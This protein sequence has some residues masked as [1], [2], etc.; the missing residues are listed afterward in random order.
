MK[1]YFIYLALLLLTSQLSAQTRYNV[2]F[3]LADD[4][5]YDAM[6]F[7]G[8]FKGLKTPNMDKMASGGAH[9]KNAF[10][11]TALCSPSR[12][13][14]LTG[15]YPHAH[16]VVD[17]QSPVPASLRFFPE[18]LQK[19]GYQTAFLGKWHMGAEGEQ[20]QKGFDH[21][22][23]FRGQGVYYNPT[24]F[25]NGQTKT[26]KDSSY[27]TDLLTDHAIAFLEDRNKAKPFFVYLS[28]KGVHDDFQAAKRHKGLYK[29]L[30]FEAPP[31][32]FITATDTAK[33]LDLWKEK[34]NLNSQGG[35]P[36]NQSDIPQ[37]VRHQRYSWHGV[38]YMYHGARTFMDFYPDY[39][40]TL[41]G[42]DESIGK[43]LQYLQKNDL[44]KNTVVFYMG[45]NGFS[46]G[47]HGLIDKRHAYEE[48]MRVPLLVYAP[49]FIAPKTGVEQVIQNVDIAPTIMDMAGVQKPAQLQGSSFLPL[50]KNQTIAWRDRAF[51]E[52][53]WEYD[54]PQTPS[55]FAVRTDQYKYI[56][57]Y[58]VWDTNELYDLK[59]DPYE[60]NNLIRKPEHAQRALG[61]RKEIFD[62]LENTGGL[63]IPLRPLGN[64]RRSDHIFKGRY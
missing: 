24:L 13:T 55:M 4:H 63:Q 14:I 3:I 52:Y 22:V 51:Y 9:I 6:G 32:M 45:D 37:W 18:Y 12:A 19:A 38:D 28:H 31:S 50:L 16:T 49:S 36:V 25:I 56:Y 20:K 57:N 1:R 41:M 53:Y 47:E 26:Y 60:M 8:K 40:E 58:G 27:V 39:L 2:V 11:A 29:N 10:V 15:L 17:N 43:V 62:W 46:F 48:S 61:F 34:N 59:A 21:W 5:R 7:M 64:Q 23:S 30:V 35:F 54:F 33:Y 44:L 42:V